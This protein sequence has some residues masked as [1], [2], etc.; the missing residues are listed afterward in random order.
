MPTYS[1]QCK[2]CG[3]TQDKFH[4][5]SAKPRVKCEQCGGPCL[6]L[7]GTG[8]GIIFK[9]SG[10]YETDYKRKD[11]TPASESAATTAKSESASKKKGSEASSTSKPDG[12]AKPAAAAKAG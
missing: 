4:A 10:F 8:A 12:A 5:M 7:L 1:Y 9:G 2:R 3:H 11:K 6:R